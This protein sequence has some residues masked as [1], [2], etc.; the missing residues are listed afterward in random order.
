MFSGFGIL[1][2]SSVEIGTG[3]AQGG[4]GRRVAWLL[5]EGA[6][7][8]LL[9]AGFWSGC[10][11]APEVEVPGR[12]IAG[13]ACCIAVG[14]GMGRLLNWMRGNCESPTCDRLPEGQLQ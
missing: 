6:S 1:G 2:I 7:S 12:R 3:S 4:C 11:S 5:A 14:M 10:G 9:D 13:H 8:S